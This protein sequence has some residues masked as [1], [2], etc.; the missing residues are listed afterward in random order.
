[1]RGNK[2]TVFI[3]FLVS[4]LFLFN[5][6]QPDPVISPQTTYSKRDIFMSSGQEI[7]SN[8][9][10][11][12]GSLNVSYST[13]TNLLTYDFTWSGLTGAPTGIGIYGPAPV[14]FS[15]F[16]PAPT[17]PPIQTISTTGATASGSR[18]GTLLVDGILI[19]KENMINQ[20]YYVNIRTA[21]N[22]IGEI[23]GQVR[24]Y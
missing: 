10:T 4:V 13:V 3:S 18:S 6:C 24:F 8:S 2:L 17:T 12:S 19:T 20:L 5:S 16:P 1:M 21:A 14:G 22:P 15:V 11:A 9:S 23:R 7:P